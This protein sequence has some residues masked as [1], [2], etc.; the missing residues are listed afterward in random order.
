MLNVVVG[1]GNRLLGNRSPKHFPQSMTS[2]VLLL[3]KK[4]ADICP[5]SLTLRR[6]GANAR[7]IPQGHCG[8][9]VKI[10]LFCATYVVKKTW[11]RNG[12]TD[13]E[14]LVCGLEGKIR[15]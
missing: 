3:P 14:T 2:D 1:G 4:Y 15:V 6:K 12:K 9:L 8:H 10:A 13:T 11:K 5:R 7:T